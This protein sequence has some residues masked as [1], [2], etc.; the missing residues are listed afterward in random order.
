[1]LIGKAP[2]VASSDPS[3]LSAAQGSRRCIPWCP[4]QRG[5]ISEA[6]S[7][8]VVSTN[9]LCLSFHSGKGAMWIHRRD[10]RRSSPTSV[11]R[12]RGT[13]GRL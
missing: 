8:S 12:G 13:R 1:M 10:P 6:E 11:L 9:S 4:P 3:V 7:A 5:P 2:E